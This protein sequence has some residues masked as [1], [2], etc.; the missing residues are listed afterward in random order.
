MCEATQYR[1]H[2]TVKSLLRTERK[3]RRP[4]FKGINRPYSWIVRGSAERITIYVWAA[5]LYYSYNRLKEIWF[6]NHLLSLGVF[7]AFSTIT[8]PLSLE[9]CWSNGWGGCG[10]ANQGFRRWP[11]SFVRR[12]SDRFNWDYD[13]N[14]CGRCTK[15]S[16]FLY[17][18]RVCRSKGVSWLRFLMRLSYILVV[19]SSFI[20]PS[21][22][23]LVELGGKRTY[24]QIAFY[25]FLDDKDEAHT[26]A[27]GLWAIRARLWCSPHRH[28]HMS[29]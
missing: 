7:V 11:V 19:V 27:L 9:R 8:N 17:T 26:L 18:I 12:L 2:Q 23:N 16:A 24:T 13:W 21:R 4:Q 28:R 3:R 5:F 25:G 22:S 6:T 14:P 15:W 29:A 1:V 10:M 20:V